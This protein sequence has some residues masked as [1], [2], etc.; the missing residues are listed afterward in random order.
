MK[1]IIY[2]LFLIFS[3]DSFT[4]NIKSDLTMNLPFLETETQ[5]WVARVNTSGKIFRSFTCTSS[6]NKKYLN[7][8]E[9][10]K[11]GLA[12]ETK[13]NFCRFAGPF[14]LNSFFNKKYSYKNNLVNKIEDYNKKGEIE[15][16][17]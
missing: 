8:V 14:K 4:Q 11:K 5:G 15:N 13:D 3:L 9:L 17:Y 16:A 7:Y 10:D 6:K 2:I 12:L 1:I